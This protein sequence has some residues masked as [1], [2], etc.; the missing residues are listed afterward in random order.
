[1]TA[2]STQIRKHNEITPVT[3][4]AIIPN[5]I[6][7]GGSSRSGTVFL[8]RVSDWK[9]RFGSSHD[10]EPEGFNDPPLPEQAETPEEVSAA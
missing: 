1:M 5:I 7:F 4:K 3:A 9:P 6:A 2:T 8:R 10:P